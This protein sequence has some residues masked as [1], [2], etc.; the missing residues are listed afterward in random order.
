M[1]LD[2][3]TTFSI[4][5][6]ILSHTPITHRVI[7]IIIMH[8]DRCETGKIGGKCSRLENILV[9]LSQRSRRM[10]EWATEEEVTEVEDWTRRKES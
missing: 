6:N 4:T 1:A 9:H 8:W 2:T 7:I 5:T 3:T 10:Q